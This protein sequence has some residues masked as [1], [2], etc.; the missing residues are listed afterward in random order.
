[1][2]A[3]DA[4]RA[5]ARDFAKAEAYIDICEWTEAKS[6]AESAIETIEA[7]EEGGDD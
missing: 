3:R 7:I 4:R 1:M 2:N 5:A 6:R